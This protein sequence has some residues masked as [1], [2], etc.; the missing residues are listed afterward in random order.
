M[1]LNTAANVATTLAVVVAA[2]FGLAELRRAARDRRD[3]Q[4]V[5][6][7]RSVQTQESHLAVGK[8]LRLS[9]D[10]DPEVIRA[11]P[12][13]LEAAMLIY[14]V[15]EMWGAFVYEGVVDL[16]TFD[17]MVGGWVRGS[18]V[19]LR[20]WIEAERIESRNANVGEW[21]QWLYEQLEADPDSGKALGAHV[22]YRGSFR[23]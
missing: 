2:A 20:R 11:D 15:C 6:I 21:W 9:D 5:E 10:A 8:I 14:F 18:W 12:A 16:H 13:L 22:A 4:A 23:R 19:R 3:R 17:R 7:V 1:D